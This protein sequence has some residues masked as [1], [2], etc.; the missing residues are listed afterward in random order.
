MTQAAFSH[1]TTPPHHWGKDLGDPLPLESTETIL[2]ILFPL[3]KAV[4]SAALTGGS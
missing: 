4:A 2:L 3:D 1:T